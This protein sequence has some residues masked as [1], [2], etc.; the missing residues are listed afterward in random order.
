MV[1]E[2]ARAGCARGPNPIHPE[3]W[4]RFHFRTPELTRDALFHTAGT[5]QSGGQVMVHRFAV[6]ALLVATAEAG[7]KTC[8]QWCVPRHAS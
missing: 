5:A 1:T 3:A 6:F 4:W 7:K 8:E 2:S